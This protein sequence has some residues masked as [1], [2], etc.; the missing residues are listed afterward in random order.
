M[1][2]SFR[3][4][5]F[6]LGGLMLAS[7]TKPRPAAPKVS[8]LRPLPGGPAVVGLDIGNLAPE[9]EGVDLDGVPFKLSDYRGKVVL[10]DFWGHW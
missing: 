7:C 9:I 1:R 6:V 8:R 2:L 3:I 5:V 10:L 4:L